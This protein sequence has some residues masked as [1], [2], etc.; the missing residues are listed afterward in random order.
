M[1][2]N[3]SK[4]NSLGMNQ[5]E[6]RKAYMCW[7]AA[8]RRGHTVSLKRYLKRERVKLTPKGKGRVYSKMKQVLRTALATPKWIDVEAMCEFYANR[9]D[10]HHVDHI[11]PLRGKNVCGLNVPWNLQYLPAKV[12]RAK[13]NAVPQS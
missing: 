1:K 3:Y 2:Q 13:G 11:V 4:A 7:K 9:P 5:T 8:I 12:N 10:G 6:Y